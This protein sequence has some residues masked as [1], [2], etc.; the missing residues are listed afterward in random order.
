MDLK[1]T[2]ALL[3]T[4]AETITRIDEQMDA[5]S[6]VID[7]H[8]E[9]AFI[10]AIFQ[11]ESEYTRSVSELVNDDDEWLQW[12]HLETD[13]G[14]KSHLKKVT[15]NEGNMEIVHNIETTDDLAHLILDLAPAKKED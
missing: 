11:L 15:L 6:K 10:Q 5:L 9:S 13:M 1:E 7:P 12:F 14:R 3:K 8:P 2:K 4:W